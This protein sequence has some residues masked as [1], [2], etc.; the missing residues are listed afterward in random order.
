M[1]SSLEAR[2]AGF[3]VAV[4]VLAACNGP[5]A[6]GEHWL[7]ASVTG[8][9]E[10]EYEGT[11]VFR[12]G[13]TRPTG[14]RASFN[15]QSEGIGSS[16]GQRLSLLWPGGERPAP[17]VYAVTDA[18]TSVAEGT[19]WV[20]FRREQPGR[21]EFYVSVSGEVEIARSSSERVEGSFRLTAVRFRLVIDGVRVEGSGDPRKIDPYAP[22]IDVSGSFSAV[23]GETL[24]AEQAR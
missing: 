9:I 1:A 12:L 18:A 6:A 19:P 16:Q 21:S 4:V 11:G 13:G 5:T 8:V 24:E 10:T 23:L 7:R 17:G 20:L 14:E 15:L 3:L 2:A 22:A